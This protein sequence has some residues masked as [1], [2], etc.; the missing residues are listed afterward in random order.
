[1][2]A[3]PRRPTIRHT[4][5]AHLTILAA[6][7]VAA[8]ALAALALWPRGA[9]LRA[10]DAAAVAVG[11]VGTGRA[12]PPRCDGDECEV[13][14]TRPDGSLVEVTVGENGELSASTR[15]VRQAEALPG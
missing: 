7:A 11:W 13:D 6:A 5:P 1:M 2:S 12:Q 4:A 3:L 9:E 14:L 15:S 8:V 10:A